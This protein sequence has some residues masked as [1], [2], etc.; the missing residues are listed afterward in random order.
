MRT[1]GFLGA[2]NMATAIMGGIVKT[3]LD[4]GL[5]A[6]DIAVEKTA[7]LKEKWGI[8]VADSPA[9]LAEESDYLFL[10]V[11]PQNFEEALADLRDSV[12]KET[13]IVSIAAG[14]T[15][16]YIS[17]ALGFAARVVLV[18]PNTPL[19][20]GSGASALSKSAA[21]PDEAFAYVRH[22][23]D[24]A[25][26]TAVIPQEKMNEIIPINGSS[27]AF[28]YRYAQLFIEYGKSVGLEEEVCLRLFAQT[29]IGS[30][31]M[32][33][34]SGYSLAELIQ[35]VSS[36]GGTTIAGLEG[37]A[38]QGL[39]QAVKSCCEKCVQRAKELAR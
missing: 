6:Y 19:L 36:R 34:E 4:A 10:A 29:M 5:L 17:A 31:R 37:L 27:P 26:I 28:L 18:M 38:E 9:Q 15:A 8:R 30:A 21:V 2:G 24:C 16:D 23:F 22:I 1:I 25:G 39:P 11:K 20:L 33:T 35:M 12:K 3:G 13:V 14:I 7:A 32:M